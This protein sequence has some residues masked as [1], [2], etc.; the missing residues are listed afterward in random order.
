MIRRLPAIVSSVRVLVIAILGLVVTAC[1][2][3]FRLDRYCDGEPPPSTET[4]GA[5]YSTIRN[6]IEP[7]YDEIIYRWSCVAGSLSVPEGE[8]P[9]AEFVQVEEQWTLDADGCWSNL[10]VAI[11]PNPLCGG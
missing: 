6:P 7:P 11:S 9:L 2:D 10:Q 3:D 1:G 8:E 4:Y 5:G